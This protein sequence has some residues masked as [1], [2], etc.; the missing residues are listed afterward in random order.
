M[1]VKHCS[2][3]KKEIKDLKINITMRV[4]TERLKNNSV[5]EKIPN[6]DNISHEVLCEECFNKFADVM[7]QMNIKHKG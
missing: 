3:C 2:R 4:E 7:S 6:L 1:E 5:W